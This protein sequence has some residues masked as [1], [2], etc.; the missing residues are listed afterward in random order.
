MTLENW[1]KLGILLIVLIIVF[2]ADY[3]LTMKK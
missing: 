3:K 1:I 2:Y